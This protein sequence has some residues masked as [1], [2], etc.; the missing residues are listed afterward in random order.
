MDM[1]NIKVVLCDIDEK[2]TSFNFINKKDNTIVAWMT[3]SIFNQNFFNVY[4]ADDL[5]IA[6][7][8]TLYQAVRFFEEYYKNND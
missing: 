5:Q 4:D 3:S 8:L 2:I 6:K 1:E 7:N